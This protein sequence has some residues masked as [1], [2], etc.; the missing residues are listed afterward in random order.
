M[1]S[2]RFLAYEGLDLNY[3][4]I[5]NGIDR[6]HVLNKKYTK[7]EIMQINENMIF[8]SENRNAVKSN[9]KSALK[10]YV[11][12]CREIVPVQRIYK[13][14][15]G[16]AY[17]GRCPKCLRSVRARVGSEGTNQRFFRGS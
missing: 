16:T 11:P 17:V 6:L 15:D 3:N 5:D 13:N 8:L 12:I 4:N 14:K 1:L 10:R 9:W 7:E 2:R